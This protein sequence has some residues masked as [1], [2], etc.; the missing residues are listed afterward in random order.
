MTKKMIKVTVKVAK[1]ADL[2]EVLTRYGIELIDFGNRTWIGFTGDDVIA[3]GQTPSQFRKSIATMTIRRDIYKA[4]EK[5][6]PI[7]F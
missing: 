6:L 4:M 2:N 5:D 1:F 7:V 3:V